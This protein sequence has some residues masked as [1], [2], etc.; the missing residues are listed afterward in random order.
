MLQLRRSGT[1]EDAAPTELLV[2]ADAVLQICRAA[3][4]GKMLRDGAARF[5]PTNGMREN[6]VAERRWKNSH[7]FPS[8]QFHRPFRTDLL[9]GVDQTLRVWLIFR[10]A[11]RRRRKH[12]INFTTAAARDLA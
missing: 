8:S 4:A 2:F 7:P 1:G 9:V 6:M 11:P 5:A 10:V 12:D 3:G